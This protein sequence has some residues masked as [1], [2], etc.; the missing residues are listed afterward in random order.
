MSVPDY[1]RKACTVV[2][3]V[4]SRITCDPPVLDTDEDF[5][6]MLPWDSD[7]TSHLMTLLK[8]DGWS[9]DG[10]FISDENNR[11]EPEHR[12]IS[13]SRRKVNLI[14]S[15]SPIFI[16]RFLAASSVAKRLNLREK[17]DRIALFQAV[18]YGNS[19][20]DSPR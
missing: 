14:M 9:L 15:R 2:V 16:G 4:G 18:L 7:R 13:Y 3:A 1:V 19:C 5:L 6:V 20:E 11:T 17:A 12:F 10:S 8:D